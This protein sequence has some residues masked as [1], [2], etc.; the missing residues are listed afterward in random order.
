[1]RSPPRR[2]RSG[3]AGSAGSGSGSSC[4]RRPSSKRSRTRSAPSGRRRGDRQ[5]ADAAALRAGLGGRQRLAD[6]GGRGPADRGR[7]ARG[8]H[9]LPHRPRDQGGRAG[10]A[11]G[12]RAP[13]RHG[14]E[15]RGRRDGRL[16]H[17]P[18]DQEPLRR[19]ARGGGVRDGAGRAAR[20]ARPERALLRGAARACGRLAGAADG[21]GLATAL[22]GGAGAGGARRLRLRASCRFGPGR[23]PSCDLLAVLD[24]K[25]DV[26]VLDQDVFASVA[27]GARVEER[28]VDLRVAVAIVSSLRERAVPQELVAFGEVGLAGE[29][30]AVPRAAARLAE[31]ASSASRAPSCRPAISSASAPRSEPGW[32]SSAC[33]PWLARCTRRWGRGGLPPCSSRDAEAPLARLRGR[34]FRRIRPE[35]GAQRPRWSFASNDSASE[36]SRQR[37]ACSARAMATTVCLACSRSSLTTR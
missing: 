33:A 3:R 35:L 30:R 11:Q 21:G 19:R 6:P 17:G 15:L 34:R 24:R 12:A 14:A 7:E 36:A 13:R 8:D 20:G 28:A 23:E 37:R 2:W 27:G 9:A 10:R 32:S 1:M 26:H 18:R 5:C 22:G 4:R 25:A 31:A 16:P 29:V